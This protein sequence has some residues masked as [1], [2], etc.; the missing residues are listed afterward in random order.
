V[1]PFYEVTICRPW[2]WG[3]AIVGAPKAVVPTEL[4]DGVVTATTDC[5]VIKV[6]HAQDIDAEL[7]EGDWEWATATL[8]LRGLAELGN[9]AEGLL[10]EGNIVLADLKLSVGDADGQVT[11]DELPTPAR[12]RVHS[13]VDPEFGVTDVRID[14]APA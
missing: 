1:Q 4:G 9:A 13:G 14:I 6:R 2:H 10:Y 3:I 11:L 5:L 8:R 7:F 12:I